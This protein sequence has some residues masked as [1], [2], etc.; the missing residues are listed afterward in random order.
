MIYNLVLLLVNVITLVAN[1]TVLRPRPGA[2][3]Y[4]FLWVVSTVLAAA[5]TGVLLVELVR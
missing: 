5:M 3:W 2:H 1:C 4:I